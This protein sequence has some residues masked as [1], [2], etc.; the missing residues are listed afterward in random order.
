MSDTRVATP[1]VSGSLAA[2]DRP[3]DAPRQRSTTARFPPPPDTISVYSTSVDA[4]P[5]TRRLLTGVTLEYVAHGDAAA[6]PVI[7]LHG[8]T[9]SWKSFAPVLPFL[10]PSIRA[11]VPSMRGHGDS[12]R[13]ARNYTMRDMAADIVAL[14]DSLDIGS[15]TVV[16]HSMGAR[17]AMRM[18]ADFPA[19]VNGL[20]LI[21]AF[22]PALTNPA[23]DDLE[24]AISELTDPVPEWFARAFQEG[25]LAQPVPAE[26]VTTMVAESQKVPAEVWQAALAG[27]LVDDPTS[28]LAR[29]TVPAHAMWGAKDVFVPRRDQLAL[30]AAMPG[31]RLETF[32]SAGHA[33]H[34]EEPG[35]VAR[36]IAAL[37]ADV[38]DARLTIR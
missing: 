15:A 27:F 3:A 32:E 6:E 37:V 2:L 9:D 36:A 20:Q 11:I 24:D 8:L 31:I 23:L 18:A 10:P 35:R 5:Y 14:M 29:L 7:L 38:Q 28:R 19:R 17:V 12:D 22:A 21:G 16:G 4:T 26:F 30:A 1:C 25:T 33:V 13:P 34:W